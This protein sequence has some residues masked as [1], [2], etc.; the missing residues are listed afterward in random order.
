[1]TQTARFKYRKSSLSGTNW[2]QTLAQ[3]T[4]GQNYG[5]DTENMFREVI[6]CASHIFLGNTN[7]LLNIIFKHPVALIYYSRP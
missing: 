6:K 7:L 1:L 5:S 4:E 3:V 2:E